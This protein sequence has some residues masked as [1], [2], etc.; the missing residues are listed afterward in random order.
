M[1]ESTF[2]MYLKDSIKWK[3]TAEK[4]I[5]EAD[6]GFRLLN[7][8]WKLTT[9]KFLSKARSIKEQR[10]SAYFRFQETRYEKKRHINPYS[11]FKI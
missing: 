5:R 9:G 3:A 1:H 11:I 7:P 2:L 4:G 10:F 6:W 8:L